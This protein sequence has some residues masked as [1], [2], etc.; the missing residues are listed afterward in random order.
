MMQVRFYIFIF[1]LTFF[2]VKSLKFLTKNQWKNINIIIKNKNTP[3]IMRKKVNQ[4]LYTYYKD[5]ALF[6]A[7]EFKKFHRYKCEHISSEDLYINAYKGLINA[8]KN[9]NGN[10]YFLNYINIYI[11]SELYITMTQ[12]YPISTIPKKIRIIKKK[13][14]L[15]KKKVYYLGQDDIASTNYNN[16]D[17]NE[18]N[19]YMELWKIINMSTLNPKVKKMIHYKYNFYFDKIRSNGEVAELMCFSEEH[20]RIELSKIKNIIKCIK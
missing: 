13:S 11:L 15:K 17:Y 1:I 6:K 16:I 18:Y 5:Y 7:N 10:S 20:V 14:Y 12:L 8:I 9:Y 19:E 3:I 4:I 2:L